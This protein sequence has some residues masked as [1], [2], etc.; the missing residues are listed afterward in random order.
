MVALVLITARI[1]VMKTNLV[2][3]EFMMT[4]VGDVLV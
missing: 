1:A 3:A 2:I 4:P